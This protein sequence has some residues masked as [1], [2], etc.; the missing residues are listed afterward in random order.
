MAKLEQHN[1]R[2]EY[3]GMNGM[4]PPCFSLRRRD[5]RVAKR[6]IS[7]QGLGI[8]NKQPRRSRRIQSAIKIHLFAGHTRMIHELNSPRPRHG[9]GVGVE[10]IQTRRSM[11]IIK[12]NY[13]ASAQHGSAH[14]QYSA[15]NTAECNCSF[16]L[17]G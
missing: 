5:E 9:R 17:I 14:P 11:I 3:A 13:Q 8:S 12:N 1:P 7:C 4:K 10:G 6:G 16:G 15:Q 2:S